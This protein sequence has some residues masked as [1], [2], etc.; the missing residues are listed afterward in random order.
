MLLRRMA[1]EWRG[2][3][4]GEG[5]TTQPVPWALTKF[6]YHLRFDCQSITTADL[7][8]PVK[9]LA[10]VA[11]FIGPDGKTWTAIGRASNEAV[12]AFCRRSE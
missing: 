1:C 11:T 7:L 3:D 4:R 12:P 8:T 6:D 2:A 5:K 9:G 10:N